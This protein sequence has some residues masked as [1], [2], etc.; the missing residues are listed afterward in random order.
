VCGRPSKRSDSGELLLSDVA[1]AASVR[2][3][4][5]PHVGRFV[6]PP[7]GPRRYDTH[8]FVSRADRDDADLA[9]LEPDGLEVVGLEWSRPGAAL[10]RIATGDLSAMDP[11]VIFLEALARYRS[12]ADV[13]ATARLRRRI[14]HSGDWTT[15]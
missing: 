8:F 6:T 1:E 11:T 12:A 13:M 9:A 10:S 5:I 7:G 2:A 4:T 14:D 3:G 15:I